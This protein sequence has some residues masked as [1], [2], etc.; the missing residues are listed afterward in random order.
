MSGKGNMVTLCFQAEQP[1]QYYIL[2]LVLLTR[3]ESGK[4]TEETTVIS[5]F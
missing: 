3:G 5:Q 4:W 2:A 1:A